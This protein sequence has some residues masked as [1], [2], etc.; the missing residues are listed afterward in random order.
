MPC[1]A[2]RRHVG[3]RSAPRGRRTRRRISD[4]CGS[5]RL[6]STAAAGVP[7]RVLS[8]QG[9]ARG[10][11]H[12]CVYHNPEVIHRDLAADDIFKRNEGELGQRTWAWLQR[13][14]VVKVATS[15]C[16]HQIC[17]IQSSE[18]RGGRDSGIVARTIKQ[19]GHGERPQV[20]HRG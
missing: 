8:V 19:A 17:K 20:T 18:E 12:K 1:R 2:R 3:T 6:S 7:F 9:C 4:R 5:Q 13:Q 15:F 16:P 10:P 14:R 11:R